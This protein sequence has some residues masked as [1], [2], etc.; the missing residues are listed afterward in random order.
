MM[1]LRAFAILALGLTLG[2]DGA[3][4]GE[5]DVLGVKARRAADGTYHSSVT[6]KHGDKGWDH[7]ANAWDVLAPDGSVLDERVLFHPHENEQPFTRSL[8]GVAVPAG[9][10]KVTIR[11]RDSVHGHGGVTVDVDLPK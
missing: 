7:Y 6:V 8:G 9:I 2:T 3:V 4:A 11:A 1:I 5:E 10:T